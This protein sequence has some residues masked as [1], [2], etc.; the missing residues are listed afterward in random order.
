ML[1][2]N[3]PLTFYK[4]NNACILPNKPEDTH[5]CLFGLGGVIDSSEELVR[6]SVCHEGWFTWGG[7]YAFDSS[8]VHSVPDELV[9]MGLFADHWGHFLIDCSAY[10]WFLTSIDY[11]GQKIAVI[12]RN[13]CLTKNIYDFFRLSGIDKDKILIIKDVTNAPSVIVPERAKGEGYCYRDFK[14]P[15]RRIGIKNKDL[16]KNRYENVY[17]SRT[18]LPAAKG[19]ECG[20]EL[21]EKALYDKGF[22]IIYPEECSLEEQIEVWNTA[23]EIVCINGTIPLN[24][25]FSVN[26]DLQLIVLNKTPLTHQN[27]KDFEQI[28]DRKCVY[29]DCFDPRIFYKKALLGSGPFLIRQTR[30]FEDYFEIKHSIHIATDVKNILRYFIMLFILK[31]SDLKKRIINILQR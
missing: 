3:E 13:D 25:A 10:L 14:E 18:H 21:I 9:Y 27:L 4:I 1:I 6:E 8:V 12:C 7:K 19:K 11:N 20:E 5:I 2:K 29:I 22:N 16:F 31:A 23:K 30:E 28:F 17:F 26:P 15:F 24:M